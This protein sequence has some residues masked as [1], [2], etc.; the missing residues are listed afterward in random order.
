MKNEILQI[1]YSLEKG[2]IDEGTAKQELCVLLGVSKRCLADI[3]IEYKH[4]T[5]KK[6]GKLKYDDDDET[7]ILD[8]KGGFIT[9]PNIEDC[10][11]C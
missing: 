3:E 6:K 5:G 2:I 11:V 4:S 1:A 7:L 8:Y 10:N 9:L